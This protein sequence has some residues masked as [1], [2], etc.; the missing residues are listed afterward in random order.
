MAPQHTGKLLQGR[1]IVCFSNDWDGDPLSKT[2]LMR[3]LARQNRI[4]WINSLGN[5]APTASAYDLKRI[6]RK[7]AGA[8]RGLRRVEHNI[9][10]LSPLA[11]P[12]YAGAVRGLNRALLRLQILRAMRSLD[13][14]RPLV[15]SFLPSADWV[16]GALGEEL[17][18]YHC[19]DEFSAF[20]DAPSREVA[21]AEQRL[22]ERAHL[23]IASSERLFESKRRLNAN[24]VLVR[25]G[26]DHAHFSRA[27]D[28]RTVI[29]DEV[30]GLP[31]P[32]LGFFGLIADWID[33][34]LLEKVAR[35]HPSG[36][37][38]LLG[39]ARVELGALAG[40]RNVHLLGPRPYASLPAYCKGFDAALMPFRINELTLNSNPLKV[41]EYLAAGLPVVSTAIPEVERIPHCLIGRSHEEFLEQLQ[42]ALRSPGPRRERSA[43]VRG[44]SWQERLNEISSSVRETERARERTGPRGSARM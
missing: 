40:L 10:V 23:V 19:V 1:D 5:R 41:R 15:W 8:V 24:T 39:R 35:A 29:P 30:A 42:Q 43:A 36:S 22:V 4:L 16:A 26:V 44:E 2:H 27:L 9:H 38:V 34:E 31:R 11:V 17:L 33:L 25:H 6:L 37:L 12:L 18:V 3:L 13:F 32:V 21:R 20:S 7:A 14:R 28:P